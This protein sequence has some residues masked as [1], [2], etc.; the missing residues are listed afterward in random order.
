M[1]LPFVL[2]LA[3]AA[4]FSFTPAAQ[5]QKP[6]KQPPGKQD[7]TI[8][9]SANPVTFSVPLVISGSVKGVQAATPVT[10]QRRTPTS[11]TFS[12]VATAATNDKGDYTFTTRPKANSVY[13]VAASTNP[14]VNSPEMLVRVAPLVGFSVNDSSARAGQRITFR[15]TVRPAHD[16]RSVQIQRKRADGSWG[17][18]VRT[19]LRD[20]GSVFSSYRRVLTVRATGTYRVRIIGHSDHAIGTSRER[21]VTV[22]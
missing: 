18:L 20:A 5:A 9:A 7:V 13:R 8:K 3:V 12:T 1:R 4:V 17:T 21:T 10:L 15:G 16:G 11:T 2:L 19:T 14:V 6:P 22:R